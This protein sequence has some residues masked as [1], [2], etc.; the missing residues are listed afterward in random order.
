MLTREFLLSRGYCCG[1]GC[2]NCPYIPKYTKGSIET[3]ETN[4]NKH[5]KTDN[6]KR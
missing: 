6:G 2:A 4:E 3:K 5:K 1:L